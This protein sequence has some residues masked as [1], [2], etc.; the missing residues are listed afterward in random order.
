MYDIYLEPYKCTLT[1]DKSTNRLGL[2]YGPTSSVAARCDTYM[3]HAVLKSEL[4]AKFGKIKRLWQNIPNRPKE[5]IVTFEERLSADSM[6][7]V[8]LAGVRV[9]PLH[10]VSDEGGTN[11]T[12]YRREEMESRPYSRHL[13]IL[14]VPV[15]YGATV[16]MLLNIFH[17]IKFQPCEVAAPLPRGF[18]YRYAIATFQTEEAATEAIEWSWIGDGPTLFGFRLYLNYAKERE[19]DIDAPC[20][21]LVYY[22]ICLFMT[23]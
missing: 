11:R 21:L 15:R 7:D 2:P 19:L 18:P 14:N 1:T 16:E 20:T 13:I 10:Y 17:D 12:K 4:E 6:Y 8:L 9:R 5:F 3:R 22:C 23:Y